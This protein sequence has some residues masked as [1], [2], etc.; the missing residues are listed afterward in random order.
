MVPADAAV[1]EWRV[2]RAED[3]IKLKADKEYVDTVAAEVR[4]LRTAVNR[5]MAAIVGGTVIV[6]L[7]LFATLGS[8]LAGG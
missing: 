1:I 4:G 2:G 5:L 6:S 7:S 8:H 3:E